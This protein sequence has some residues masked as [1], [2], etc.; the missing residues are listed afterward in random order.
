MDSPIRWTKAQRKRLDLAARAFNRAIRK[1]SAAQPMAAEFLP[2]EVKYK[3]LKSE[4]HSARALKNVVNSLNRATKAGALDFVVQDDGSITTKYIRNEYRIWKGVRERKK[5]AYRKKRGLL[6]DGQSWDIRT[7]RAR[8]DTMSVR[9]MSAKSLTAFIDRVSREMNE[10]DFKKLERYWQNYY[11]ALL[12]EFMGTPGA[13]EIIDAIGDKIIEY[14][15]THSW[16]D[17]QDLFEDKLDIGFIYS[18]L[19]KAYRLARLKEDWDV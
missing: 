17:L 16:E 8:P 13:D 12:T 3:K 7:I 19:E 10:A 9:K 14:S 18:P 6:K 15:K 5:A 2:G 11:E 4:I 1:A